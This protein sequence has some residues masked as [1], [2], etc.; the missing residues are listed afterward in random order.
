[1]GSKERE[2]VSLRMKRYWASR[3]K[4]KGETQLEELAPS[5]IP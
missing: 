2:E 3:R 5:Q 1:M 4:G